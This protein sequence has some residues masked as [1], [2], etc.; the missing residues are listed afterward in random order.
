[1]ICFIQTTVIYCYKILYRDI[2]PLQCRR[3]AR[4]SFFCRSSTS[5]NRSLA[6]RWSAVRRFF[7]E[8]LS[9]R[10]VGYIQKRS[11]ASLNAQRTDCYIYCCTQRRE[12]TIY[13]LDARLLASRRPLRA[14]KTVTVNSCLRKSFLFAY[15]LFSAKRK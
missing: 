8:S 7:C 12:R 3:I 14:S 9:L 4:S 13:S 10:C 5:A 2:S 1:M 6:L 15:F 11:C